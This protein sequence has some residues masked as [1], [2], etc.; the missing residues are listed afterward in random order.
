MASSRRGSTPRKVTAMPSG[1]CVVRYVGKRGTVWRIKY[2][3]ATGKQV[4]ETV[5]R[6]AER[7]E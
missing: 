2:E 1:S 7:V 5:G 4:M 6:K 3:D